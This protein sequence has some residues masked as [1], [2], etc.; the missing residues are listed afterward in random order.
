MPGTAPNVTVHAIGP[1]AHHHQWSPP[2]KLTRQ[3]HHRGRLRRD[4]TPAAGHT[5]STPRAT[6]KGTR[7]MTRRTQTSHHKPECEVGV[8]TRGGP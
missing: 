2:E 5:R 1:E 8:L 7:G 3:T 6:Q 4:H